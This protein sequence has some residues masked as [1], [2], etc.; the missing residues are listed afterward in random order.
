[1]QVRQAIAAALLAV[2]AAGALA[3]DIDRG[4]NLQGRTLATAQA[5]DAGRSRASV[6]AETHNLQADRQFKNVGELSQAPVV[7]VVPQAPQARTRAQVKA[8]L[9]QWR[10]THRLVVGELG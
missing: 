3:Q 1:M 2:T 9:A 8:E 4:D 7:A 6:V 5:A 10:K